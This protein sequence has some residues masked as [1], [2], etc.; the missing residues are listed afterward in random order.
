M[1]RRVFA[2]CIPEER[3]S[4]PVYDPPQPPECGIPCGIFVAESR[5]QAKHLALGAWAFRGP[6]IG[7]N[8]D[9]YVNIRARVIGYEDDAGWDDGTYWHDF[10]IGE[11]TGR[12]ADPFWNRWPKEW[13]SL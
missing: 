4:Q 5:G 13:W 10:P 11:L 1:S 8:T 9:D 7:V 3:C 6:D 12:T 2:V